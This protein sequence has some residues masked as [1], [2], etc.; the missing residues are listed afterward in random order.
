MIKEIQIQISIDKELKAALVRSQS[1]WLTLKEG[2]KHLGISERGL[3]GL[4]A[5]GRI[6]YC[7]RQG[8]GCRLHRSDLDA[9]LL[10]EKPYRKL[11]R[12]QKV[13]L[14]ELSQ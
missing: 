11:T 13:E 9:Y 3:R 2:S 6:R 12:P 8:V 5:K 1:P 14:K 7:K 4:I 10:F